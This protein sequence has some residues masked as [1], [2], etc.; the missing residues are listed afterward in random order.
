MDRP[1]G[2]DRNSLQIQ[3]ENYRL[4]L[5]VNTDWKDESLFTKEELAEK[6][7]VAQSHLNQAN[8]WGEAGDPARSY[9]E[10]R[11]AGIVIL[12]IGAVV[13]HLLYQDTLV[14]DPGLHLDQLT[15]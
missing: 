3:L 8:R 6:L 13:K 15:A 14:A 9:D 12:E 11:K 10:L 7:Q 5:D 2:L 4:I 1:N